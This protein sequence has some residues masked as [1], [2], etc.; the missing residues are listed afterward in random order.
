MTPKSLMTGL[1]AIALLTLPVAA[2]AALAELTGTVTDRFDDRIV[3]E[4]TTGRIL[5]EVDS[6]AGTAAMGDRVTVNG[7]LQGQTLR[8]ATVTVDAQAAPAPAQATRPA[9]EAA[10]APAAA[11][12][13][14]PRVFAD[15]PS[16]AAG[17]AP[18]ALPPLLAGLGLTDVRD[19]TEDDGAREIRALL[20]DGA[21]F[22]VDYDRSGEIKEMKTEPRAVLPQPLLDAVLSGPVRDRIATFDVDR[23]HEVEVEDDGRVEIKG[24][25]GGARVEIEVAAN[26]DLV[27]F[28]RDEG[29]R[30][31]ARGDDRRGPGGDDGFALPRP[32]IERIASEAGYTDIER[33][34]TRGRH[35]EV[36]ATNADA[37]PVRIR[38]D[39][40]GDVTREE[41]R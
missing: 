22:E 15:A 31:D 37:E 21:R 40:S 29:N 7:D 27:S 19:A 3:I 28:E 23:I 14:A 2:F 10:Q 33:I 32:E 35:A 17:A 13:P 38:I 41:R 12:P 9:P 16:Q 30:R 1:T 18:I 8:D 25:A 39:M 24:A 36:W 20:P 34:E 6:D 5:V 11:T 26:G 4:T